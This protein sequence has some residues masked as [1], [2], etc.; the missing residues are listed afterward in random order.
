MNRME[1]LGAV[2]AAQGCEV[3]YQ[4]PMWKHTTFKIGGPADLFITVPD[5][6]ALQAVV[7]EAISLEIPYQVIGRGSNLLV[8]DEGI[9]GA[10]LLLSGKFAEVTV[11]G[12]AITCGA[13]VPLFTL[14]KTALDHSLT[15]LEFAW[16]IPGS[17]GGALF[18]NAG[19]YGSEM[20]NVVTACTHMTKDGTIHTMTIDQL[21]LAYR[22]SIYHEMDAVIL[23]V[24]VTLEPGDQAAISDAMEDFITRRK[25]K[26]PLE[27]PSAGSVFKRPVGHYAGALVEQCGLKGKRVGGAMVSEK[28]AG[29]IV[30]DGGATCK[31]VLD[32]VALI[33]KTVLEET[34]VSLECEIRPVS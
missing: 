29:F 20:K 4:E 26:Q 33:Q 6:Q 24:T 27:Y 10:V 16:G 1:T 9:K 21:E 15:G 12:N 32:L 3:L 30:N 19:A 14:C 2:A 13:A 17:A 28:H 7:T 34:G 18:M 31:D 11:E 23:S 8:S 22:H 25:T 5:E